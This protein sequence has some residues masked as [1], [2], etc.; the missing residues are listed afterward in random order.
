MALAKDEGSAAREAQHDQPRDE[1]QKSYGT[2]LEQLITQSEE[3]L[4]RAPRWRWPSPASRRAWTWASGCWPWRCCAPSSPACGPSL[5]GYGRFLLLSTLGNIVGGS[6]FVAL[7][8]YGHV[9]G[10]ARAGG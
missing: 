7:L 9:R 3:E 2:V 1:A 8:E 4:K 10:A 6:V 5:A